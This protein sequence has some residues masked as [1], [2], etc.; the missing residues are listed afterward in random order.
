MKRE[1]WKADAPS[2]GILK[3]CLAPDDEVESAMREWESQYSIDIVGGGLTRFIPYLFRRLSDLKIEARDYQIIRGVYYKSWWFQ[4][5]H[6]KNN[7]AFLAH[8]DDGFPTFSL[9][10]GVALQQSVYSH[11]PRTR[12]CDDVDVLV[13]PRDRALAADYLLARGFTLDGVYTL[14]YTMNFRKSASFVK[15]EISID[16]CWG[17]YEYAANPDYLEAISLTQVELEQGT[18]SVLSDTANLIHTCLHGAGWNRVPSTR[19]IL[20]AALLI[21]KGKIDWDEFTATIIENSWQIPLIDQLQYLAEFGAVVPAKVLE[22][23]QKSRKSISGRL[24]YFYLR[25]SK[26][27]LR[28]LCRAKFSEYLIYVT[29]HGMK[30]SLRNYIFVERMVLPNLVREFKR[31]RPLVERDKN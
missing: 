29:L 31:S 10:K 23:L 6:Q 11:D 17:L 24:M 19:W 30:S 20:D 22:D 2:T 28:R 13:N 8:L 26:L 7:L 27:N 25:Q 3:V 21:Q 16:L 12:P 4:T 15:G 1:S 5:V 14:D 9:L 18:F